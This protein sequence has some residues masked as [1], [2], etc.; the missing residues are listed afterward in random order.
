[1]TGIRAAKGPAHEVPK[2][3]AERNTSAA[4][5][6]AT[7]KPSLTVRR[8]SSPAAAYSLPSS[9]HSPEASPV[10]VGEGRTC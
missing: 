1:M 9:Y 6:K 3:G 10:G 8:L 2:S 7:T 5:T 4:V